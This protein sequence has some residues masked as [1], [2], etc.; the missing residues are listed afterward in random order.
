MASWMAI[1]VACDG[2]NLFSDDPPT[3]DLDPPIVQIIEPVD[4]V[5][6]AIGDSVFVSVHVTDDGGVTSVEIVGVFIDGDPTLGTEKHTPKFEPKSVEFA[7]PIPDTTVLRYLVPTP[8]ESSAPVSLIATARDAAGN[9]GADT[10]LIFLGGP[11]VRILSPQNGGAAVRGKPLYTRVVAADESGIATLRLM[12]RGV[13]DSTLTLCCSTPRDSTMETVPIGLPADREGELRLQAEAISGTGLLRR[14]PIVTINV[15]SGGVA[16]TLRPYVRLEVSARDRMELTDGVEVVVTA[17]DDD[18]GSG[19]MRIGY[20]VLAINGAPLDTLVQVHDTTYATPVTGAPEFIKAFNPFNVDPLA[21]PDSVRFVVYAFAVDSAGNCSAAV[22][23]I[24]QQLACVA[25]GSGFVAEDG[26]I[27][28]NTVV[29][30]GRTVQL[31]DGGVIADAVVDTLRRRL[32][33]SNF[34]MNRIDVLNLRTYAFDLGNG[35]AVGAQ[36]WGLFIN[37]R[38]DTLLVAN[39][40]GTNISFVPLE[41]LREDVPRRLMTP[42]VA[43]FEIPI[44]VDATT[45]WE[46]YEGWRFYDLSDRPQFIA[47]DSAGTLLYSTVPTASATPG[48]I[49]VADVDPVP[50]SN[51][52]QPEVR[53]LF[54]ETKAVLPADNS[55][56]IANVDSL[57]VYK[58]DTGDDVVEI[59]DHVPGFSHVPDSVIYSGR[60]PV[61]TAV[62]NLWAQGSDAFFRRG[63][64]DLNGLSMS[65]TTFVGCI[66]RSRLDRV[67]RGS[68]RTDGPDHHVERRDQVDL[69]RPLDRGPDQ[70]RVRAGPRS[71][72]QSERDAGYG[73]RTA[74]GL[75]L[76]FRSALA[77]SVR[78]RRRSGC[79]H[80]SES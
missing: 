59:W 45:G 79:G 44:S 39:S 32:Y 25:L 13:I 67:R 26:G 36:P 56:V 41:T 71:Q 53:L 12:L 7:E 4:S 55:V 19:I 5:G 2:D 11:R 75:L 47:V 40:G 22:A 16:D 43:L 77:R 24:E 33:L 48:T 61:A 29:V 69:Q 70:Q 54:T 35:V 74:G 28:V 14:S 58:V 46:K 66:G 72:S 49:R 38:E 1:H 76:H 52:D 73:P 9:V 8:D 50:T 18:A 27:E 63:V 31:P 17:R 80:A 62:A 6:T 23:N 37:A 68:E 65:D 34:S 51:L 20:S 42:N 78:R 3:P 21:L 10:V 57:K 15:V 60:F 64:W 30:N